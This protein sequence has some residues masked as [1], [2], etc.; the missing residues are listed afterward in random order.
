MN[1][2]NSIKHSTPPESVLSQSIFITLNSYKN[3][4]LKIN[5]INL[6]CKLIK[7]TNRTS[8]ADEL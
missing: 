1:L 4:L 7:I 3:Y 5:K 6:K 2:R 8:L